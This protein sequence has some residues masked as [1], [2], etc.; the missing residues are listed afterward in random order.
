[1][2]QQAYPH[3]TALSQGSSSQ[4]ETKQ[5]SM[6][7]SSASYQ[8]LDALQAMLGP[9]PQ[10][11][12]SQPGKNDQTGRQP[13]ILT[14]P[15]KSSSGNTPHRFPQPFR[16]MTKLEKHVYQTVYVIDCPKCGVK[17][18]HTATE[19]EHAIFCCTCGTITVKAL[20]LLR[21]GDS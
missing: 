5:S 20:S 4:D 1:M 6:S 14:E 12:S 7:L 11:L 3:K 18:E 16:A 15:R 9:L 21:T 19:Q 8:E 2:K 17:V 10:T 13:P